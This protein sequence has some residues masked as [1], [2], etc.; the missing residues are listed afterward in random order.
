MDEGA[1]RASVA[2]TPQGGVISPLLA[3]IYLHAFDQT[4]TASW[5]G[6][7]VRYA[8]DGVVLC[9]ARRQLKVRPNER[10]RGATS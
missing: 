4:L 8:G 2:G 6:E 5:V 10:Q 9:R 7:L 3:N 1:F